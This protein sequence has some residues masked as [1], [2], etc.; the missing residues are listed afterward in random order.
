MLTHCAGLALAILLS[1]TGLQAADDP[2]VLFAFDDHWLPWRSNLQLTLERPVKVAENPV[3]KPGSAA[4]VDG[5][6]VLLYGT[7]LNEA[8]KFR[9]WYIAEP[10]PDPSVPGDPEKMRYYRPI[11]YAESRD[12]V[13]WEKPE[14][15]LVEF[16]GNTRNNL[17]RV[18]PESE[19]LSR[20]YDYVS[21]LRDND[22]RDASRR[23]KMVYIAHQTECACS[24]AVTAISP[25]GLRWK[26]MSNRPMT[27]GGFES[28][29]LVRFDG[30]Y[31]I[32][33][34]EII[35]PPQKI[36]PPGVPAGR[37]MMVYESPDFVRW[38]KGA[39]LGFWRGGEH[40]PAPVNRGQEAHLGAGLW[41]RGNVILGLYGRWYGDTIKGS[42]LNPLAGL[43]M[44]LGFIVS[45]DG[46]HYREPVPRFSMLVHGEEGAW[47]SESLL[48]G[49]AFHNT[50]TETYIWYSHW[51]T[52]TGAPPPVQEELRYPHGWIGMAKMPRDRFG[53]LGRMPGKIR[54]NETTVVSREIVLAHRARMYLNVDGV[55]AEDG[56]AVEVLGPDDRVIG[57]LTEKVTAPGLKRPVP[58]GGGS[59]P[60]GRAFRIKV[61]WARQGVANPRLYAVYLE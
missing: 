3:M 52:S 61:S 22:D 15:G 51:N 53:Y 9:M 40:V 18:E 16:R 6:G 21:V 30:K 55:S 10:R 54:W 39:A 33:G 57:G 27:E 7:V 24:V 20:P 19:P 13:H 49:T 26:M 32:S 47:D 17:V 46:V 38:S 23:Y 8:G 45:N 43:K 25:D 28:S 29:G 41:N 35:R 59:L 60:V 37:V 56:L 14:L 44:D 42:N 48:Q 1:V 36:Y 2:K 31:Y 58:F 34:Q 12:G 11:A 5:Y 4:A 50:E